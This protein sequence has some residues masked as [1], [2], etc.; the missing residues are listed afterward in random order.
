M[1]GFNRAALDI[2]L[3]E[4]EKL[5]N[6]TIACQ[7]QL[8]NGQTETLILPLKKVKL[9]MLYPKGGLRLSAGRFQPFPL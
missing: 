9:D 2:R 6:V 1:A 5:G 3:E 7:R 8:K 4:G